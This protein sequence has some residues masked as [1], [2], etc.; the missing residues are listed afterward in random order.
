[1]SIHEPAT[2][3]TDLLLCALAGWLA[4]RLRHNPTT[5]ARWWSR[6]LL[7]TAASA[8]IG[9]TYHGFAPNLPAS[10]QSVWWVATLLLICATSAAMSFSLMEEF[11]PADRQRDARTLILFKLFAFAGACMIHPHFAV[12]IIDYGLTMIAWAFAAAAWRRSWSGWMLAGVGLSVAAAVIQQSRWGLAAWF[13]H[14]D[15]YHVVQSFALLA[16]FQAGLRFQGP[17]DKA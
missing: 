13:N 9:G 1:M 8:L 15:L 11:L 6:A 10:M 16:F 14:N 7:L 3:L 17:P 4:W 12:V 2:L 5:P